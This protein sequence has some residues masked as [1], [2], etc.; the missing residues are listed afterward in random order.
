[1]AEF[2]SQVYIG[3]PN[4]VV[5]AIDGRVGPYIRARY[6]TSYSREEHPVSSWD[7]LFSNWKSFTMICVFLFQ[8][9][10]KDPIRNQERR[11]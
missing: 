5:L 1:M 7:Q 4:G 10:P 3:T 11:K 9:N 8:K 6:Y 2:P